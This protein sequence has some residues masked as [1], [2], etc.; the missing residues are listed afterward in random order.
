MK[1]KTAEVDKIYLFE[2]MP[3]PQA[4]A[5]L[6]L[7]AVIASMVTVLYNLAD[8]MF[9]GMLNDPVEVSAITISSTISLLLIG[10][11]NLCGAGGS[12]VL[13]RALGRRDY[14]AA[15][16]SSAT[17]IWL[18]IV[19]ALIYSVVFATFDTRILT[20]LGATEENITPTENYLFWTVILGAI[21]YVLHIT[22]SY[23]VRTEGDSL[24]ASIGTMTG[25][26]LNIILDPIFVLDFG[27][28]M[29]AAGAGCATFISNCVAC[30]YY[31]VVIARKKGH[32]FVNFLPKHIDISKPVL[33]DIC[34]VGI[35]AAIQ[36]F[37]NV[38]SMGLL[39][40]LAAGY[41]TDVVAAIGI[42]Y[43]I[44]MVPFQVTFG[45][46]SG[47]MALFSYNYG[48]R[49]YR[50]AK[51]AFRFTTVISVGFMVVVS[52]IMMIFAGGIVGAFIK[53]GAVIGHGEIFL[54]AFL[55]ALPFQC[56][57]FMGVGIYQAFGKGHLALFAAVIRKIIL[58]I[59]FLL[60]LE[61][62]WPCYGISLAQPAAEV[63]LCIITVIVVGR[64]FHR[65]ESESA[66]SVV[67]DTTK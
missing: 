64:I 51:E 16:K 38:L 65:L 14:E 7:P 47:V 8:T 6:A 26:I 11:T 61:K 43:K 59:S 37:L 46:S 33:G 31:F 36:N 24:R 41:G 12:S 66:P 48:S 60:I 20:A 13:G 30:I 17:S 34:S 18:G 50:R 1:N 3:I 10:V 57:D 25:C 55:I 23:L 27:L 58:E 28:G 67:S 4:V 42:A 15:K 9:V 39:N 32:T 35:P 52:A 19:I 29:G 45:A 49:N 54:K 53:D 40:L 5:K 62:L 21:P 63:V 44:H 22:L 2:E 56:L